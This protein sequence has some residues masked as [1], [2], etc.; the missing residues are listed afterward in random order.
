MIHS[1][2]DFMLFGD[3]FC[4]SVTYVLVNIV[5]QYNSKKRPPRKINYNLSSHYVKIKI[6]NSVTKCLMTFYTYYEYIF[7]RVCKFM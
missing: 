4:H 6:K 2:N 5:R 7:A 3:I 1:I